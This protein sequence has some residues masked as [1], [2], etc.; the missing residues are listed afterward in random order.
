MS[1]SILLVQ[2]G[3]ADLPAVTPVV[4]APAPWVP[5]VYVAPLSPPPGNVSVQPAADSVT[6]S[7]DA[8]TGAD[9]YIIEVAPAAGGPWKEVARVRGT[10][11]TYTTTS[12][13]PIYFSVR[14]VINGKLGQPSSESGTPIRTPTQQELV[15]LQMR[16]DA[17]REA[18]ILG[19]LQALADAAADATSKADAALQAALAHANGLVAQFGDI[20]DADTWVVDRTY[21]KGDFVA[22][23]GKLYRSLV[24]ENV[25]QQPDTTP[26]MWEKLG[27]YSSAGEAIAAS[28]SMASQNASEIEAQANRIDGV[29]ARLPADGERA[30]SSVIVATEINAL[31]N[32][33]TQLGL[34]VE[35]V[36]ASLDD[37][38]DSSA[39]QTLSGR[40]DNIDG[41]IVSQGQ[42]ITSVQSSTS[43]AVD[44]RANLLTNPY[45]TPAWPAQPGGLVWTVDNWVWAGGIT[46]YWGGTKVGGLVYIDSERVPVTAGVQYVASAD[47]LNMGNTGNSYTE[48]LWYNGDR[49]FSTTASAPIAGPVDLTSDGTFARRKQQAVV[50]SAP[51]GATA[52]AVRFV[53]T[54]DDNPASYRFIGARR[55][56]LENGSTITPFNDDNAARATASATIA[57]QTKTTELESQSSA[58]L[59]AIAA[60][61]SP[62]PNLLANSTFRD[63][64]AKWYGNPSLT[65]E[66]EQQY[67]HYAYMPAT[68][69]GMATQQNVVV[70]GAGVTYTLA[71]DFFRAGAGGNARV[72]L[73]ALD[74]NG[75]GLASASKH[76]ST[77][78]IRQWQRTAVTLTAPAG[79]RQLEVRLIWEN[80]N[81]GCSA[82]RVKLEVG[83][84]ATAW[85][86]EI[87]NNSTAQ[88]L[89]DV[90]SRATQL[91]ASS[92]VLSSAVASLGGSGNLAE[93]S[94]FA[95]VNAAGEAEGW[96]WVW[97]PGGWG[98]GKQP[99]VSPAGTNWDPDG[100]VSLGAR[101]AGLPSES[102]YGAA[103]CSP[104]Q[105]VPEKRY[106]F[107]VF[108]AS[109]RART[110]VGIRFFDRAGVVL[111]EGASEW[112]TR[113]DQGGA[114][115]SNWN[116]QWCSFVAPAGAATVDAGVWAT[117]APGTTGTDAW[118]WFT[119]PMLEQAS[120]WQAQP[121]AWSPG[122]TGKQTASAISLLKSM[123]DSVTGKA[124]AMWQVLLDVNGNIGGVVSENDGQVRRFAVL[125]DIFELIASG[126]VGMEIRR[127]GP[128]WFMRFYAASIQH[129]IGINFG[130]QNNLSWWY[131]PN[132]GEQAASMSNGVFCAD[133]AGN[134][135]YG[136]SLAAGTLHNVVRTNTTVTVGTELVNGPFNTLGRTRSI[137]LSFT[138]RYVRIHT[139]MGNDGFVAG[140]GSNTATVQ[141]WR[142]IGSGA[143]TLWKTLSVGGSIEIIN[144]FDGPDQAVAYW[145]GSATYNDSS[146]ST[147][148]VTYRA[149]ITDY[150]QQ[151][152]SHQSGSYQ[153]Q[154]ITQTLSISSVEQ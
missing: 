118:F 143:E 74:A 133:N 95:R 4:A 136:G 45:F 140:S 134:S 8:V 54:F 119:R 70:D 76:S 144:A 20:L 52:V 92:T 103:F 79:T 64:A 78:I 126:T 56:K 71:A 33:N 152:V 86:D 130:A 127:R 141:L 2:I 60:M 36:K 138:R 90:Q 3:A 100:G 51:A 72:E 146:S 89:I 123:V 147:D 23:D 131:G 1:R 15:E 121:S 84:T 149:V 88:G 13:A 66:Y 107:S 120:D 28:L 61:G 98:E 59:T 148:Q 11:Y 34:Q 114:V 42:A 10:R 132:V 7:W 43:A 137:V 24:D 37:K 105:A 38:A 111:H 44:E 142:K 29:A 93:N 57:L 145:G 53:W 113:I 122:P 6:L 91:E 104:V 154:E 41:Q 117:G 9:E 106:I 67:G 25:G 30:A 65:Y 153:S 14:A 96:R 35:A 58:T 68:A 22:H 81:A 125:S 101:R 32:A 48:L 40:I 18:R 62:S 50:G 150:T 85:S 75:N 97:N 16:Q 116:Y 47:I 19:D 12:D 27:D 80:T 82:R 102:D 39:I 112:A 99:V 69:G 31:T 109:H 63:K 87:S 83:G 115:L 17:E 108:A 73:N 77:T 49:H 110:R 94:D 135:Y 151:S 55:P 21:P 5:H 139:N 46:Q 129:I 124:K 26:T 128:G